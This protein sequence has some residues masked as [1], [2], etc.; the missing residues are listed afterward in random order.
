MNDSCRA[1]CACLFIA[2][3]CCSSNTVA[4]LCLVTAI[5]SPDCRVYCVVRNVCHV[6][7][8]DLKTSRQCVN[9][10]NMKLNEIDDTGILAGMIF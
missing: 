6:N 10:A 2:I 1:G 3:N 8:R 9:M 7:L 5:S 4:C